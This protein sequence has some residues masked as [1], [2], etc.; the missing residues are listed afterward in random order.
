VEHC[1]EHVSRPYEQGV[2]LI[3]IGAYVR[4]WQRWARS[5]LRAL[6]EKLSERA[7]ELVGQSLGRVG[8]PRGPLPLLIPAV[9]GQTMGDEADGPDRRYN[10]G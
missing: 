9:P 8:L 1:V 10:E 4:R 5:G 3:R 6:R 7:L 2:H